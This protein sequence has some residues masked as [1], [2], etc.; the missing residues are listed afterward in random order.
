[1]T[2]VSGYIVLAIFSCIILQVVNCLSRVEMIG[3][4]LSHDL[5]NDAF[6]YGTK[7]NGS[8]CSR[9]PISFSQELLRS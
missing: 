6:R 5:Y 8:D 1:M 4:A 2:D 3:R 7:V 9:Y